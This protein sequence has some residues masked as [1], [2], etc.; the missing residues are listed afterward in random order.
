MFVVLRI[1]HC[2]KKSSP[3]TN[4]KRFIGNLFAAFD[5]MKEVLSLKSKKQ[6]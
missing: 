6:D 4:S 5:E 1:V 3:I 2:S